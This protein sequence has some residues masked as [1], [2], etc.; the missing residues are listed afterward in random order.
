MPPIYKP[1]VKL[2]VKDD[3]DAI[4]VKENPPLSAKP[5]PVIKSQVSTWPPSN[6]HKKGSALAEAGALIMRQGSLSNLDNGRPVSSW[7][8][9]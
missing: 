4:V 6:N 3:F 9:P 2:Q 1:P 5:K 8:S 7:R